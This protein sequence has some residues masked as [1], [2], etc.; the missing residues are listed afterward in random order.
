M[1]S[2]K[3]DQCDQNLKWK[4]AQKFQK[5]A[6]TILQK[7]M[8]FKRHQI[9]G[10]FCKKN[11]LL[12]RSMHR[13]TLF[14]YLLYFWYVICFNAFFFIRRLVLE[15]KWTL[16]QLITYWGSG[17]GSVGR[18]VTSNTAVRIQ[19]SAKINLYIELLFTVNCVLKDENKEK[20]GREWSIF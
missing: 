19:S 3:F 5:V 16:K 4:T 15:H 20:R 1:F 12:C 9:F 14:N 8:F 13:K 7:L 17:C 6:P 10:R 11:W 18:A 2:V